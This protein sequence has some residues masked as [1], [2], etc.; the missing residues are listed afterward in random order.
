MAYVPAS[1]CCG[2]VSCLP[3]E[4]GVASVP[5]SLIEGAVAC[6][7]YRKRNTHPNPELM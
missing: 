4:E 5:V 7:R 3:S 1:V 6:A 2:G